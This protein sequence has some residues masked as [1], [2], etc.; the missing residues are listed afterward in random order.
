MNQ[1]IDPSLDELLRDYYE[2]PVADEG[3]SD[4]LMQTTP[5]KRPRY[6]CHFSISLLLGMAALLWQTS[7][8]PL[9]HNACQDLVHGHLTTSVWLLCGVF[10]SVSLFVSTWLL[11]ES[12]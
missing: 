3:F 11:T 4:R 7:S 5:Q 10:A 9:F 1:K 2:A 8:I 12:E 6:S